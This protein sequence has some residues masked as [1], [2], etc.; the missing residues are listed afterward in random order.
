MGKSIFRVKGVA[1]NPSISLTQLYADG[2]LYVM[3]T[4]R[5][6]CAVGRK[7]MGFPTFQ[8]FPG[9][10]IKNNAGYALRELSC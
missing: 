2:A 3:Y 7:K 6:L 9:T 1:N 4:R 8:L 5:K 10:R